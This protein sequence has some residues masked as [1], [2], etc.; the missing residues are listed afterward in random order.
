[1]NSLWYSWTIAHL[2]LNN[3]HSLTYKLSCFFKMIQL[4][5]VCP[6]VLIFWPLCCVVLLRFMDSDYIF[7]FLI[8]ILWLWLYFDFIGTWN[9]IFV[10]KTNNKTMQSF[11]HIRLFMITVICV[12]LFL[13]VHFCFWF[14]WELQ[15]KILETILSYRTKSAM[16]ISML[17]HDKIE[18]EN[19]WETSKLLS[20]CLINLVL[21]NNIIECLYTVI[22]LSLNNLWGYQH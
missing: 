7:L 14:Q 3:N 21:S 13:W 2:A 22:R 19:M 1:M 5:A 12:V 20:K 4:I 8:E 6:F 16:I 18:V 15:T 17:R 10:K 11:N 9:E